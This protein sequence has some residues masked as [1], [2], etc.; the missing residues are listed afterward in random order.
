[1]DVLSRADIALK[2]AN[3]RLKRAQAARAR[4]MDAR[5]LRTERRG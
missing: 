1:M 3:E 2:V 4:A 5:R